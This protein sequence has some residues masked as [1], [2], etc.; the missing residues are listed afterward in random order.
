MTDQTVTV[1]ISRRVK[2]GMEEQFEQ[3]SV[4]M[5]QAASRFEGYLGATMLKPNG[6]LDPEYRIIFKFAT[7]EQLEAWNQSNVRQSLLEQLQP[8]L[9]K[10]TRSESLEGIANWFTLPASPSAPV[11][12]KLRMTLVSWLALYPTVTIIFFLLAP[13]LDPLP[14]VGR[15]LVIT[16]IVMFLMSYVLMPRFTRWFRA[17]IFKSS[18]HR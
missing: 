15:T 4:E 7:P 12:N 10:Q 14:L 3:L 17:W 11:P 8:M 16:G 2:S 5:T 13:V 18:D 9:L 1:V 6:S